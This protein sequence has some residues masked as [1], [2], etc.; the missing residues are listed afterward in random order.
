MM[1]ADEESTPL[2]RECIE[3]WWCVRSIALS[4]SLCR[5]LVF[6]VIIM[7]EYEK[8]TRPERDGQANENERK[9]TN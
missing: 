2:H 9:K 7:D 4:L 6:V 8:R 1:A 3:W 5:S